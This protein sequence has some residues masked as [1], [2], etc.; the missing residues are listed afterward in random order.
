MNSDFRDYG[1]CG[2][3]RQRSS[4][5]FVRLGWLLEAG[6]WPLFPDVGVVEVFIAVAR[7]WQTANSS[8]PIAAITAI[9]RDYGDLC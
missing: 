4:Q 3:F 7:F 6:S 1:D 5:W 2:H 9:P 8:F